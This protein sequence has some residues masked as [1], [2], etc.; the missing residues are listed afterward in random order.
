MQAPITHILPVATVRRERLMPAGGRII[1]RRGQQVRPSDVIAEAV[2]R[3]EHLLL[4]IS[5]GLGLPARE[6]DHYIQRRAGDEVGEGDVIAGPVGMGRRVV[7]APR[8]GTIILAGGGQVLMELEGEFS[9]LRAG[10]FGIVTELAG[11]RGVVIESVGSLIQCVWG[12]GK[13][14]FGLLNILAHAADELVTADMIEVSLRAS[15]VLAGICEDEKVL[16][17]ADELPVRGMILS[18]MDSALVPVA[19]KVNYPI[20]LVEGFGRL[21]MNQ[22]AFSILTASAMKDIALN[23]EPWSRIGNTRPE[24]VVAVPEGSFPVVPADLAGFAVGQTVRVVTAPYKS[25]VGKISGLSQ[26]FGLLPSGLRAQTAEIRFL[27]GET[28]Q[29]PLVNLEI[30]G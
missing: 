14:N 25:K 29:V 30:I 6:A 4:D 21:P 13:I 24:V 28:A 1:A 11:D 2:R 26:G 7:R 9:E 23:A 8:S 12:N 27:T 22:D 20:V 10:Y 17:S 16:L 15:V 5:N 3:P 18:S 19:M